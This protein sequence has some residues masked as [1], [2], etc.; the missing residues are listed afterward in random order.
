L[1]GPFRAPP[2]LAGLESFNLVTGGAAGLVFRINFQPGDAPLPTGYLPDTGL[3][4][5]ARPAGLSYGWNVDHETAAR[6]RN[7]AR[8]PDQRHDTFIEMGANSVWEI[9]VPSGVYGVHVAAGDPSATNG[10]SWL[11]V[12]G[13]TVLQ[14]TA[15]PAQRWVEGDALVE[16]RD[17]RLT[18]NGFPPPVTNRV[19]FIEMT[20]I[21][22]VR[23]E[24]PVRFAGGPGFTVRFTGEA[25]F[26]YQLET[27]SSL[28]IWQTAGPATPLFDGRFQ[29]VDSG[30]T[31]RSR[32]YR[33]RVV[34]GNQ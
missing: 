34:V 12:E 15:T 17:G 29:F 32:L 24:A 16:V 14:G 27:S 18:L 1:G 26:R 4:F 25:G 13:V 31:N 33:A 23:L 6:D 10:Q 30:S 9:E 21:E 11:A 3:P 7:E 22:P 2:N 28:A 20:R 5:G 19:C 8:S